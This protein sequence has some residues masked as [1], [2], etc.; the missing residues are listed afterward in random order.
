MLSVAVL[1]VVASSS[2]R[3]WVAYT[4]TSTWSYIFEGEDTVQGLAVN[5][6]CV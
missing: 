6:G 5:T 3:S 4:S 1:S 2:T